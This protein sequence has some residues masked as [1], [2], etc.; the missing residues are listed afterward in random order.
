MKDAREQTGTTS[1]RDELENYRR[2]VELQSQ[3]V[4]LDRCNRKTAQ[5]CRELLRQLEREG[6][7]NRNRR[8]PLERWLDRLW[9]LLWVRQLACLL[10]PLGHH[11]LRQGRRSAGFGASPAVTNGQ[12]NP[13]AARVC[14]PEP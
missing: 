6:L 10:Q 5:H 11:P 3:L 2:L 4:E 1:I 9:A 14:A 13:G 12:E 8:N 7:G